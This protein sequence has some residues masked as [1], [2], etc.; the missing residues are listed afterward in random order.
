MTY[1]LV[2]VMVYSAFKTILGE[3]TCVI[4]GMVLMMLSSEEVKR[5]Q[6]TEVWQAR[7][8]WKSGSNRGIH[9]MEEW[10]Q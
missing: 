1:R 3:S 2:V 8:R 10:I 4:V 6:N 9:R 5:V 7:S